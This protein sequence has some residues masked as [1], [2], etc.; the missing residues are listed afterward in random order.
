[1]KYSDLIVPRGKENGIAIEFIAENLKNRLKMIPKK[2]LN[3]EEEV[4]ESESRV[5]VIMNEDNQ[6][7]N[8]IIEKVK[9]GDDNSSYFK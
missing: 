2:V 5:F 3:V 1:M 9:D 4:K 8:E 6:E 7:V